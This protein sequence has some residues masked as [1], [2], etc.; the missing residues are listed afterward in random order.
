MAKLRLVAK[1]PAALQVSLA[2][3]ANLNARGTISDYTR[4]RSCR[5][6]AK[7]AK[8]D[9]HIFSSFDYCSCF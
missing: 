9:T 1:P 5:M 3:Q 7:H 4:Y 2:V 6:E 8:R